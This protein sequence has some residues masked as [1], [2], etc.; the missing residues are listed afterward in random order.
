MTLDV[1]S[2]N[3]AHSV[4]R[5]HPWPVMKSEVYE[6]ITQRCG[7]IDMFSDAL[8]V[9]GLGEACCSQSNRAFSS[10]LLHPS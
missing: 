8:V 1:R 3:D 4:S 9:T 7:A 2:E 5:A 10:P 6:K